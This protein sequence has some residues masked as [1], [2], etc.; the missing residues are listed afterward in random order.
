MAD[1]PDQNCEQMAFSFFQDMKEEKKQ[2]FEDR[3]FET[4]DEALDA[5]LA[6]GTT[7]DD[8]PPF[9]IPAE[10]ELTHTGNCAGV[11]FISSE[12]EQSAEDREI[13]E[14]VERIFGIIDE[15]EA[16][17]K[18][19]SEAMTS[20]LE[21]EIAD[22]AAEIDREN[23]V[24][25]LPEKRTSFPPLTEQTIRRAALGFL[26]EMNPDGAGIRFP[27]GV[28]RIKIDAGA[29]FLNTGRKN[30]EIAKTVLVVT[31]LDRDKCWI[32][33]SY[34]TDLL[35]LLAEAKAEKNALEE[36]LKVK[37]PELKDDSLF[38]ESQNWDFSRSKSRKYHACL[39]KIEK[40][41][42]SIYHGSKFERLMFEQC[43]DEYYL[44]VPAGLIAMHELP[45]EWGLVYVAE[46]YSTTVIRPAKKCITTPENR[47]AF[48]LRASAACTDE[49]LFANGI[50]LSGSGTAQFHLLPKRR[51]KYS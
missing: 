17:T 15:A 27:S 23:T 51:K 36:I 30:T 38:P 39:R 9:D 2:S 4:E 5:L 22:A 1:T 37:E 41:E 40:I 47:T 16:A 18:N 8:E 11:R 48:A 45:E 28:P 12:P 25:A 26:A 46:N 34:K 33:A 49:V 31:C 7:E 19:S 50:S 21:L 44:A 13:D 43:A 32:D 14:A 3:D 20:E 35:K 6:S 10:S 24:I 29:F 42:Y